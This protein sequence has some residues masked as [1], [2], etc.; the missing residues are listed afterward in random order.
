MA[1]VQTDG[2]DAIAPRARSRWQLV[3]WLLLALLG[4][5]VALAVTQAW[6]LAPALSRYLS[7]SSGRSVHFDR[8]VV[9]LSE[10]FA[11]SLRL[12]GVRI[13]NAPWSR[14]Q[15]PFAVFE[16]AEFQL[17]G[18]RS[19]GRWV[20]SRV[21]LSDGEVHLE[22]T[23]DGLRNWR[24]RNPDHRG[25]GRF[26][27]TVL[28]AERTTLSFLHPG[29]DL[30]LRAS[31]SP[32]DA[33]SSADP[34]LPSRIDFDGSHRGIA[35]RGSTLAGAAIS[36][37]KSGA[38]F[39]LRGHAEVE[40]VR[41]ELDGRAADLLRE[42]HLEARTLLTA[43]SLAAIAPW[44][45]DRYR[46]AK[47][48]RATAQVSFEP[49]R[50]TLTDAQAKVGVTD[51]AGQVVWSREEQKHRLRVDLR[52]ESADA[53]DLAWLAGRAAPVA[54]R[55]ASAVRPALIAASAV[56]ASPASGSDAA[57]KA[58]AWDAEL[59]FGARRLHVAQ[60]R[61]VQSLALKAKLLDGLLDV[62]SLDVGVAGGHATGSIRADLRQPV[63]AAAAEIAWRGVRLESLLPAQDESR[64][65][66]GTLQGRT[67]LTAKGDALEDLLA[68]AAGSASFRIADGTIASMLDAKMG[69]QGGKVVRTFLSGNEPLPLPC[70]AATVDI[71]AGKAR[72]TSLVIDSANTRTTGRGTLHL[73]QRTIDVVLTPTSKKPGLLDIGKSI[74]L[75]GPLAKPE[76]QLVDRVGADAGGG[77]C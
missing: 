43:K 63:A 35:F 29:A 54:A 38:W 76:R 27:F 46:T 33:A 15:R 70:A 30:E 77:A 16:S 73:A 20:I 72:I 2:V 62:T 18:R 39:P 4:G 74:R 52:S 25:E 51:L 36:L 37:L 13:D 26:W 60:T 47:A 28:E 7:A 32:S 65:I 31:A 40:G 49:A 57:A 11:P 10:N 19:E 12:R 75:Q 34:A 64:R 45:G 67:T 1:P 44:I 42:P 71:A 53:S 58:N 41:I 56:P 59:S 50:V 8:A 23:A 3:A 68:S 21:R 9:T 24:L 55:A 48:L 6:W 22:R 5:V 14:T 61:A 17:T 69:L 66:S